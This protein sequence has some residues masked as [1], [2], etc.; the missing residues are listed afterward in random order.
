MGV[1]LNYKEDEDQ[2]DVY[3]HG[4][5][6]NSEQIEKEILKE[7]GEWLR[8]IVVME[9]NKIRRVTQTRYKGRPAMADDVSLSIKTDKW[10]RR[11]AR[12]SGGRKTGTLWHIVND[13]TLHSGP[14][15]FIDKALSTMDKDIDKIWDEIMRAIK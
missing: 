14:T 13:G 10:G 6:L 4:I 3:L 2:L 15:H 9:L 5:E 1:K 12:V 7:S 8:A 11:Y